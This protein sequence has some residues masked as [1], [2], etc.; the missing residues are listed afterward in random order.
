MYLCDIK[1]NLKFKIDTLIR[2][3]LVK[4]QNK[5]G[6]PLIFQ[7]IFK[8]NRKWRERLNRSFTLQLH[9]NFLSLKSKSINLQFA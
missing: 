2:R 5:K 6:A 4:N 1:Q 3:T 8:I 9:W 7:D